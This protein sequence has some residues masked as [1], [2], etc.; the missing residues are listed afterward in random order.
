MLQD[1]RQ[2][3]F[4]GTGTDVVEAFAQAMNAR[5][6]ACKRT[7]FPSAFRRRNRKASHAGAPFK[8]RL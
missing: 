1:L 3:T 4:S 6:P 5:D 2:N 8:Q 7:T